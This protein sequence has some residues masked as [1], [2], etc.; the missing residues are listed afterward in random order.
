[1]SADQTMAFA[2]LFG[3][4]V[5]APYVGIFGLA[6]G[7]VIGAT[8]HAVVQ[9]PTLFRY[10]ARYSLIL[11]RGDVML[12]ESVRNVAKLMGP[13]F[14]MLASGLKGEVPYEQLHVNVSVR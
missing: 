1:M 7:V 13:A 12:W 11:G 8:G 2:I 4:L 14:V 9:L 6:W 5:L 3:A 10:G